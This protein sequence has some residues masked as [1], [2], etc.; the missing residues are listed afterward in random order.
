M[1]N[2]PLVFS[3]DIGGF[4]K[5][6]SDFTEWKVGDVWRTCCALHNWLLDIDGL[7]N[8]WVNCV[9]VVVGS[10]WGKVRWVSRILT[11]CAIKF[12]TA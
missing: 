2:V 1:S 8:E 5:L 9:H 12:R 6:E 7:N 11:E 3:K 10:D 4:L